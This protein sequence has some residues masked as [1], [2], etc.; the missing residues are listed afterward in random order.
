M[1]IMLTMIARRRAGES[2]ASGVCEGSFSPSLGGC[3]S[4]LGLDLC[5]DVFS[6][7]NRTKPAAMREVAPL[8]AT[9]ADT[10]V[11]ESSIPLIAGPT[12]KA[13]VPAAS[14]RAMYFGSVVLLATSARYAFTTMDAPANA[15]LITRKAMN[16]AKGKPLATD[17]PCNTK[18]R[19]TPAYDM[20]RTG[21]LPMRSLSAGK[22]A[23][24]KMAPKG[25]AEDMNPVFAAAKPKCF[26]RLGMMGPFIV[27]PSRCRNTAA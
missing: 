17:S 11:R 24:A 20:S 15:P 19:P 9:T 14:R 6:S 22:T 23:A 3:A 27:K 1:N 13:N 12:M 2:G 4:L 7:R 5:V 10:L 26:L 16:A 25:K 18:P 21:F 8:N